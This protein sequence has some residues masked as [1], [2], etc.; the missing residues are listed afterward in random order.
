VATGNY[1]IDQLQAAGAD[2]ALETVEAD[3]PI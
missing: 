1:G 3:F 2:W